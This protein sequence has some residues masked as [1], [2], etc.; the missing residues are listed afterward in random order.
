[1][2]LLDLIERRALNEFILYEEFYNGNVKINVV[3]LPTVLSTS[4]VP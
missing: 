1:M 3:P 4:M 2:P